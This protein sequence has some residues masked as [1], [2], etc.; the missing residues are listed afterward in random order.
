MFRKLVLSLATAAGLVAQLVLPAQAAI[1]VGA[2]EAPAA[3]AATS[4]ID[5]A[6]FVW[7]GRNYCWYNS[8]DL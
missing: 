1:G 7:G 8:H 3:L 2:F 6:Q 5:E 4:P